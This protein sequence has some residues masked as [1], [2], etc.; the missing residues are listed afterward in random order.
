MTSLGNINTGYDKEIFFMRVAYF[1]GSD[2][3]FKKLQCALKGE[4]DEDAWST[5]CGTVSRPFE[6]PSTGKIAVTDQPPWGRGAE[7][8]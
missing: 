3:P 5:L 8:A 6:T 2:E 1:T 4:V 7:G